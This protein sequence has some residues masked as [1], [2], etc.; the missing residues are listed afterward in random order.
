MLLEQMIAEIRAKI[1]KIKTEKA[2]IKQGADSS[3]SVP[4]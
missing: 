4:L 3:E 1:A 2:R